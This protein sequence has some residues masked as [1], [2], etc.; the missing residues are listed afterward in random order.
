M[1]K[2]KALTAYLLSRQLVAPEQL[3]SWTDQVQMELIWK[4]D[5]QGMHMGDMNYGATISIERFADHPARL[6]ALVGSWLETNDQDRDGLPN[7]VFDVVMLDNDLA[8]VD[9]KLQFTEAQ[10]LAED[11]AGEIEALGN[12]WSFVP[13]DL[14]VAE[15]GEVTGNGL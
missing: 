15:K 13:F 11:V 12:T 7:V 2:L 1:I 14:W 6:F 9:I 10:Y 8:D 5:T 4:P 3:D